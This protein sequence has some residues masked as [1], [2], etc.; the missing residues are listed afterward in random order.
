MT[1]ALLL[2]LV[3]MSNKGL[4]PAWTE[5]DPAQYAGAYVLMEQDAKDPYRYTVSRLVLKQTA[6]GWAATYTTGVQKNGVDESKMSAELP[7]VTVEGGAFSAGLP[8]VRKGWPGYLP[9]DGFH[10]LFAIEYP[11]DNAKGPVHRGLELTPDRKFFR[12]AQD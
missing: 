11:P 7:N 9:A 5:K 3:L 4:K 12:R 6:Q 1:R 8:P 2:G 10:G